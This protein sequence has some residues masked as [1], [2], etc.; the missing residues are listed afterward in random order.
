MILWSRELKIESIVY[1]HYD[2][3]AN[4]KVKNTTPEKV[5][6]IYELSK[7]DY[8]KAQRK[9]NSINDKLYNLVGTD[10]VNLVTQ[11]DELGS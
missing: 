11:S 3:K 7:K 2:G 4:L 5:E 8:A 1:T 6:F 10:Y 9:E